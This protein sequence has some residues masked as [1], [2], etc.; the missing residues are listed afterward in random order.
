MKGVEFSVASGEDVAAICA[1]LSEC[2]LWD[3]RARSER[4]VPP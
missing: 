4:A 1:L 3:T 2:G